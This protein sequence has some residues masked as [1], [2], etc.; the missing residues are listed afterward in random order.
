MPGGILGSIIKISMGSLLSEAVGRI[1]I[2]GA[3]GYP[4]A[5]SSG[6]VTGVPAQ[7]VGRESVF[8]QEKTIIFEGGASVAPP[9]ITGKVTEVKPSQV[10]PGPS[11]TDGGPKG[12]LENNVLHEGIFSALG[13]VATNYILGTDSNE[14]IV[15]TDGGESVT[16]DA[17]P[18]V[19]GGDV[20]PYSKGSKLVK[21]C[22][23]WKWVKSRRHRRRK[24][25]TEA[26]YNG[27]LKIQTLK[28]T[29]NIQIA[30]AKA[31]R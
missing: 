2:A 30:L 25:L 10:M 27:L 12:N 3:S 15:Y 31:L 17:Q 11:S 18:T 9:S 23:V 14:T 24:L 20:P 22:G 28:N 26:D 5:A 16:V 7:S 29:Q 6:G 21:V 8:Q 1:S 4:G 19:G 13:Q